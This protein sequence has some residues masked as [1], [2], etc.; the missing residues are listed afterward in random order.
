MGACDVG[1]LPP[2]NLK[3]MNVLP[4][5]QQ[6]QYVNVG[7]LESLLESYLGSFGEDSLKSAMLV[8]Y[9][10]VEV[11]LAASKL[12]RDCGGDPAGVLPKEAME[13]TSALQAGTL[14]ALRPL[15]LRTLDAAVKYRDRQS[16][17]R[18][19]LVI[20]KAQAYIAE[21][22]S[23]P[24]ISLGE[25]AGEVALSNNHFCTVF[26]QETGMTFT[27]YLTNARMRRAEELLRTTAQRSSEICSQVGY[28]DPHYFSYLFRKYYGMSPR[29]YRRE[30]GGGAKA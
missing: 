25:V 23:D 3:E 6:L 30:A 19:G 4:I 9:V 2:L 1:I 26:S 18:Y 15:L 17:T 13:E 24:N 16:S 7:E 28:N 21:H 14:I 29:D 10:Y 27:E 12:V 8:H 22:F 5:S 11:L 20:R